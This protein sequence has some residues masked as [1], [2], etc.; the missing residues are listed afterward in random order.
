[1]SDPVQ[2][3]K[4]ALIRE[5]GWELAGDIF[6][7]ALHRALAAWCEARAAACMSDNEE[8]R[9]YAMNLRLDA[10]ALRGAADEQG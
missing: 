4:L 7:E 3:A 5:P 1:M 6:D 2:L 8:G 10:T 9:I